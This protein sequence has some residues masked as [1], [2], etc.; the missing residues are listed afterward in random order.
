MT[1]TSRSQGPLTQ[2]QAS[3]IG[4]AL[5]LLCGIPHFLEYGHRWELSAW[6]LPH[7]LVTPDGKQFADGSPV[8]PLTQKLVESGWESA[9]Y[10]T[11]FVFTAACLVWTVILERRTARK[12]RLL[13]HL[14]EQREE[15]HVRN[16][17]THPD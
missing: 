6:G 17:R 16:H 9:I 8:D 15:P 3:W 7:S 13:Q 1:S 11:A 2:S 14:H 12:R 5:L 10:T 4:F